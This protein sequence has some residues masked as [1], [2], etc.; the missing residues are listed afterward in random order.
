M[1]YSRLGDF[2][3]DGEVVKLSLKEFDHDVDVVDLCEGNM[4]Y[5]ERHF[6]EEAGF[7]TPNSSVDHS[8]I[9]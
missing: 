2:D 4:D 6:G 5:V 9:P 8:Y 3:R 7:S 1:Q